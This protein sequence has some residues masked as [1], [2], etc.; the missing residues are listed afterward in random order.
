M[1]DHLRIRS[2]WK[3]LL[4]IVL[5]FSPQMLLLLLTLMVG[6]ESDTV[7]TTNSLSLMTLKWLQASSSLLFFLLPAFLFAVFVFRG[8]YFY[9]LGIKKAVKQNMYV[10]AACCILFS[11]PF[12]FWLGEANRLIP[13]PEW[14]TK[15]EQNTGK[16]MESFLKVTNW[17]DVPVNILIIALLPAICEELFFR[18]ALQRVMIYVTKS[19]WAGIITGAILFSALHLQFAGFLPRMF[20]GIILG[21]LYW[22]SGSLWT[23]IIAHFIF[24]ATQVLVVS[25]V[26]KYINTNPTLP[27][28]AGLVSILAVGAILY[29][30]RKQSTVTWSK[31]FET[32]QLNPYNE[33]IA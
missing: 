32:D 10:L 1:Y 6:N 30:Y 12:V 23:S 9:F 31:V 2:S 27:V 22:Y 3:Q 20:L 16:Q 18:G 4:V 25:Y 19:P 28:F 15:L 5:V 26:P 29:F 21:I 17:Y 11:F 33:F 8:K 14:M 7:N 24:N 13:L